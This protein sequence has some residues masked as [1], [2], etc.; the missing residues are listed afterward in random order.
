MPFRSLSKTFLLTLALTLAWASP[1]QADVPWLKIWELFKKG[2]ALSKQL[3]PKSKAPSDSLPPAWK[4]APLLALEDSLVH[5]ALPPLGPAVGFRP[6]YDPRELR[7]SVAAD[8]EALSFAVVAGQVA[9]APPARARLQEYSRDLTQANFRR[10]WRKTAVDRLAERAAAATAA[11]QRSSSGI[12]IPAPFQL[13]TRVQGLLGPGGPALNVAGSERISL[14]GTSEWTNRPTILGQRRSLFPSLDMRQD[15]DIRLEG[16]LSDRVKVNLLQN[17]ANQVALQNRIAVNYQGSEGDIVQSLNLGNTNLSLPGTQYVSYS[18]RNEGLFGAKTAMR[19]GP[20][21]FT[22]LASKQEGRSERAS[23]TGGSRGDEALIADL[24]YIRGAY[25]FLEYPDSGCTSIPDNSVRVFVDDRIGFNSPNS[26]PGRA[27]LDPDAGDTLSVLGTFDQL[28]P[29]TDY[30]VLSGVYGPHFKVL[31]LNRPVQSQHVLAVTYEITY[32][33]AQCTAPRRATEQVGGTIE[34]DSVMVMKLL[35]APLNLLPADST[36][37]FDESDPLVRSREL[38]LRNFYSLGSTRIDPASLKLTIRRGT[39]EPPTTTFNNPSGKA[40]PFLQILGLDNLDETTGRPQP[41]HDD[42]VDQRYLPESFGAFVDFESGTLFFPDLR[43]FA[44]RIAAASAPRTTGLEEAIDRLLLRDAHLQYVDDTLANAA[45]WRIYD[46]RSAL[47]TYDSR[48]FIAAEFSAS[49]VQSLIRL[50]RTNLVEGSEVVSINNEALTRGRDYDI[51]YDIGEV[52]LKKQVGPS[53]RLSIDYTYAPLFAQAS[54]G[55]VGNAFRLEG[56]NRSLGGAFLYESRGAQDLRPRLGEEPSRTFIGDLN[57]ELRFQPDWMTR[58]VDRLPGVRTTERSSFNVNAEAGLSVPNPNTRNEVYIDDMEGVRDAVSLTMGFERWRLSSIPVVRVCPTCTEEPESSFKKNAEIHWYTPPNAVKE[59]ELRPRLTKAEGADL[60]RQVLALSVPRRPATAAPTD[61][62]WAG[63]TYLLDPNGYDLSGAQFIELWINDFRDLDRVRSPHVRMHIDLGRVSEDQ[64]RSPEQPP[65]QLL[66][67]EDSNRDE[68]LNEGEDSG[69]DGFPN[70]EE[71]RKL[72]LITSS[73]SD[74]S[75]DDWHGPDA[76]YKYDLDTRRWRA[77]N[78]TEGNAA[79]SANP[80]PDTE[81]LDGNNFLDTDNAFARYTVDLADSA[82]S[83]LVTDVY[84]DFHG[85]VSPENEPAQDN[86]WRRYR[87]PLADESRQIFG[88]ADLKFTKH[89][90]VWF[91]G[92]TQ[93]DPPSSTLST[94]D[95]A[96]PLFVLGGLEV[97]GSRWVAAG[98]DSAARSSGTG[99]TLTSV[100]TIDNAEVYQPP[101]DP[102][103]TVS[104]S[105]SLKRREQSLALLVEHLAPGGHAESYRTFSLDEDY[106]RYSE[107]RWYITGVGDST[108]ALEYFLRFGADSTNYYEYRASIPPIP[109]GGTLSWREVHLRLTDM[110][111]A[112]LDPAYRPGQVYVVNKGSGETYVLAGRPTFTRVRRITF[113]VRNVTPDT[114]GLAQVWLDEIRA[115][116][117]AKDRGVA[118]RVLVN[119]KLANLMDY[120]LSWNGQDEDFLA[121]GQTRGSGIATSQFSANSSFAL[122]RFIEGTG[123]FLPVGLGYSRNSQQPRFTV[124]DD[125]RR[126]GEA[127]ERSSSLSEG[128]NFNIAY[129]RTWSDR[130]SPFLRY[131]VGGLTA[132]YSYQD[133][134]GRTPTSLD[135]T[136]GSQAGVQYSISPRGEWSTKVPFTKMRFYPFPERFYWNYGVTNSSTNSYERLQD[137]SGRT[138][139]RVKNKGRSALVDF[140]MDSRPVDFFHH[141]FE[142]VRNLSLSNDLMER[143]GFINL[144]KVTQWRQAMDGRVQYQRGSWINPVMTWNGSYNQGNGPDL[145]ADLSVRSISNG[146]TGTVSWSIP[147]ERLRRPAPRDSARRAGIDWLGETI[148]RIGTVSADFGYGRRSGNSRVR[149]SPSFL[150]LVGLV[151]D[152]GLDGRVRAAFGNQFDRSTDWHAHLGNRILFP[153]GVSAQ[154]SFDFSTRTSQ[155]NSSKSKSN[156]TRF[157]D[158]DVDYGNLPQNSLKRWFREARVHTLYQRS[159][160]TDYATG[161][162]PTSRSASSLWRPLIGVN[163]VLKNN[164]RTELKVERRVTRT[165]N[166]LFGQ[167]ITTDRTTDVNLNLNRSYETGQKVVFLG[168]ERT[169]KS[170]VSLGLSGV[171]SRRS[172]ETVRPGIP[173]PQLVTRSDRLFVDGTGTYNFSSNV[174]GQGRL[175]FGQN[176]DLR[177]RT[178]PVVT[179]TL[180]VE[181]SAAFSF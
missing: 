28:T 119:G 81:D 13:P 55:L 52:R 170:A 61:S 35:K 176:R 103:T 62:L 6:S 143:I 15:L 26:R 107:L 87:I 159:S 117:V 169:V 72:D 66:D 149:G 48:Y 32:L 39:A 65:N 51:D 84:R 175:G 50:N 22:V 14:A 151:T 156:S 67:S 130:T 68:Q 134:L 96:R 16:Q 89:V 146:Q 150:Y 157:P 18:G 10:Q 145:S 88:L 25:F 54:R 124:G 41:G 63:L 19:L 73:D 7:V 104:G 43:P 128:R 82:S 132:N 162:L 106:S 30:Q 135:T 141:H 164:T 29:L 53:D 37:R 101:F 1:G 129:R 102:G 90:R 91:E 83:F 114:V 64:M 121:L 95:L 34:S 2:R 70:G 126:S 58:L 40:I 98:L 27:Y 131:T 105:Q 125:I 3:L 154:S 113:G 97:V 11:A 171:Y 167:S 168:K 56:R 116:G 123:I 180:R 75:G 93:P 142:A 57:T 179:R 86:G 74:P 152:P 147:L 36:G 94:E 136:R 76:S 12:S 31:H 9:L 137:G 163:G 111:D 49:G 4:P 60:P 153:Y 80:I 79:A 20:L 110:S 42:K 115:F 139:P 71:P 108:S 122:H 120:N 173:T 69:L 172:G 44:P 99:L 178:H 47:R 85:R 77:V 140:G 133:R 100:N 24:D 138:L 59:R 46:L 174:S 38:E 144:G 33:D 165:E 78:G 118:Q 23:Y 155:Y 109:A 8:S 166:L 181:V 112:K 45:N 5:A 21:D 160:S 158:F 17:S 148:A 161:T 92:L 177:V 127:R